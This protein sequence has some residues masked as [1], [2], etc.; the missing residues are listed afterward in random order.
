[1]KRTVRRVCLSVLLAATVAAGCGQAA[2]P[3]ENPMRLAVTDRNFLRRGIDDV[4]Q[5]MFFEVEMP[6]RSEERI[7]TAPLVSA[8]PFEFWR[9]DARTEYDRIETALHTVRR[10]VTVTMKPAESAAGSKAPPGASGAGTLVEVVVRKE[11]VDLPTGPNATT[12]AESYGVFESR[13]KALDRFEQRWGADV[14]WIDH[15]RDP[16]LEQYILSRIR[17]RF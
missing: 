12:V 6:P 13:V 5:G 15:G 7:D 16:D 3:L 1:M 9:P 10:T 17:E 4:L 11:R 8:Y 14:R 2:A